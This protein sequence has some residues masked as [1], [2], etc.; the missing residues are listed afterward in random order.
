MVRVLKGSVAERFKASVLKTE[1]AK[2]PVG[3]NPTASEM[4]HWRKRNEKTVHHFCNSFNSYGYSFAKR[5]G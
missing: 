3:S 4:K 2:A 5:D 1:D